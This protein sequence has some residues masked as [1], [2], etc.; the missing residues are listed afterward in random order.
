MNQGLLFY[1]CIAMIVLTAVALYLMFRGRT[2]AVKSGAVS[3]AYFKTYDT[4][5][6][7]PRQ[8]RQAER[9]F[10]NLLESTPPF[11]ALCIAVIALQKVDLFFIAAGWSYV[12]LRMLQSYVHVTSNKIGPRS[13]LF[14]LS[15]VVILAM[16]LRLGYLIA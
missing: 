15:W 14:F 4:G 7:L 13:Q 1:P 3:A 8:A 5:E 2:A 12:G 9:C 11:Y 16:A 10:H 6:T